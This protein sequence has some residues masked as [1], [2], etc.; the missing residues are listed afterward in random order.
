MKQ[1]WPNKS[2]NNGDKVGAYDLK[3]NKYVKEVSYT[4]SN[5]IS[6]LFYSQKSY[7]S[8]IKCKL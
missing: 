2:S 5:L 8:Q 4:D 1:L 7:Q 6:N 3:H